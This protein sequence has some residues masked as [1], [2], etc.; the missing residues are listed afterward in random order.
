LALVHIPHGDPFVAMPGQASAELAC[1]YLAISLLS[2]IVGPG[3]W[4]LDAMMFGTHEESEL[5]AVPTRRPAEAA[6]AL[7]ITSP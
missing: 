4:S 5:H 2:A 6:P 1:A 7:A 3:A